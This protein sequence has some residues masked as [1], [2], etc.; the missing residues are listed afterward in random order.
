MAPIHDA[1]EQGN[2]EEVMR[3]IQEDPEIVDA[4]DEYGDTPLYYASI[5]SHVEV[6]SYL[7]EQGASIDIKG[8][9]GITALG[10]SCHNGH[11]PVVEILLSGEPILPVAAEE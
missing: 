10:V 9:D 8:R 7:L 3:L 2:L 1:A 4:T 6:V 5:E 11:V